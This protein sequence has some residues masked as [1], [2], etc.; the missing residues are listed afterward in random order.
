VSA[1]I[2]WL[3]GLQTFG[4][5]LGLENVRALLEMLD[6]PHAP[7]RFVHV[8][9]TNGKGS[10]A[11]M[12]DA[13]LG[14][15]GVRSGLFT[16]P[17]LVRVNERIRIAG[18]DIASDTLDRHLETVR[19]TIDRGLAARK[20]SA[21]P[22]FFEAIT[23]TALLAFAE[24]RVD[25][26]VLEVGL[27]GRLDATNAIDAE[28]GAIVSLGLDHTAIL[29]TTIEAIAAEK[30]GIVKP[31]MTLVSGVT[32]QTAID[33]VREACFE[34]GATFVDARARAALTLDEPLGL[35]IETAR[36]TY[37][38]LLPALAGRH[39]V[40]NV[41]VAIVLF[42]LVAERLGMLPDPTRVRDALAS[43]RWN[44]RLEWLDPGD[45]GAP[46]LLD[47]AHN[48][49]GTEALAA[50]LD[51]ASLGRPVLLF[52]ASVGRPIDEL[53]RPLAGRVDH[54]VLTQVAVDRAVAAEELLE[55]AKSI[56]GS[57]ELGGAV[58]PALALARERAGPARPVLVTGSLYLVGAVLALLEG[59]T[60]PSIAM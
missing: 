25:A 29:G 9:G 15:S 28:T 39:Q 5:K 53:L 56:L 7:C 55:T 34:R 4:I 8:A 58:G 48:P 6:L 13:M 60:E 38:R 40:D 24:E 3:Y 17:H 14:A 35:T 31:G 20:L 44:G 12:V 32:Q 1:S 47:G 33:V 59:G 50:H 27:G 18:K 2:D 45:G 21:H 42:E 43:V 16:S 54:A 49:A 37:D 30:A 46:L 23:A 51:R 52:A 19:A 10:V 41:R 26:V 36:A 57:V 22:S 11:A